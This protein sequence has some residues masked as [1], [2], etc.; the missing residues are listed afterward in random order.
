MGLTCVIT[1]PGDGK[2]RNGKSK[3]D[4]TGPVES[5]LVDNQVLYQAVRKHLRKCKVCDPKEALQAYL[6]RRRNPKFQ[7]TISRSLIGHAEKFRSVFKERGLPVP[8]D[9]I[10]EFKWRVG[11]PHGLSEFSKVLSPEY[12]VRG[13]VHLKDEDRRIRHL[14]HNSVAAICNAD[15]GCNDYIKQLAVIVDNMFTVDRPFPSK[16][17]LDDLISIAGVM[18]S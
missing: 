3:G 8:E 18:L 15:I 6:D 14:T 10:A 7:G 13:L 11:S 17:E 1:V 5:F 12:L 16:Q 9:L 4:R 2:G